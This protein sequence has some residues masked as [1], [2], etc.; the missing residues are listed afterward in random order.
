MKT[1][2]KLSYGVAV[3]GA[4]F[5]VAAQLMDYYVF[6]YIGAG[7]FILGAIGVIVFG[8]ELR[9]KLIELLDCF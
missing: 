4:L 1:I 8:K 3:I 6:F 9:K 7:L 2:E 5:G